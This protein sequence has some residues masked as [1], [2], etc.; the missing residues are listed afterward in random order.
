MNSNL[1][2]WRPWLGLAVRLGLAVVWLWAGWSKVGDLAGSGRAV[3]AYQVLPYDVAM[4][5]GAALPFVELALALLLLLGLATRLAAGVSAA[6]LLVFIAGIASAW[7]RGLAIDCGCFG[8]G[9][10][11]PAGET[12]SYLP[13]I[14]R[15]I[16]FLALAGFLLIWP[17]TAVSADGALAG[18][19]VEDDNE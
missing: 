1:R 16:G 6:L 18:E 3:N 14:L 17:R 5:V 19:P 13:E 11:L 10:E 9:G 15:D 2:T 7:S 12:P 4:V 8:V